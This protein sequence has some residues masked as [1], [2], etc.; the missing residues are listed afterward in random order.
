MSN[1]YTVSLKKMIAKVGESDVRAKLSSFCSLNKDVEKFI[2]HDAVEFAKQ[3]IAQTFLVF[4]PDEDE[5][6]P[7][8]YYTLTMKMLR[9]GKS[10]VSSNLFRRLRKFGAYDNDKES[11]DI[12]SPLI[13]QISKNYNDEHD[14]LI[15]GSKLIRLACDDIKRAQ[16]IVG[17]RTVY[18][19]CEDKEKLL[20]FYQD[21]GFTEFGKRYLD[22][23]EHDTL[24][25]RYL[26]RMLKYLD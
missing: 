5:D 24:E 23:D 15:T 3:S 20:R 9:V 21:N 2:R 22:E 10:T 19:E 4:V 25:G 7:V 11:C 17:G 1:N 8:G 12:P 26:I 6:I 16:E 13:A 18:L 14:K